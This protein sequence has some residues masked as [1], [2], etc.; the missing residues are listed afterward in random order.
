MAAGQEVTEVTERLQSDAED[1]VFIT[2][3]IDVETPARS[4]IREPD[5]CRSCDGSEEEAAR[6]V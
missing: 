2:E 1:G 4:W 3:Q 5:W 6:V